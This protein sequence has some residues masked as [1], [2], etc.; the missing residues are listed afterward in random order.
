MKH[1]TTSEFLSVVTPLLQEGDPS[2]LAGAVRGR[3]CGRQ[4]CPL[5]SAG[6]VDVRRAAALVLGLVGD[7]SV[8]GS[9]S[10]ALHD[11]EDSVAAM[12]EHALWSVWHRGG[13][14]AAAGPFQ[15]GLAHLA[16]EWYESAAERFQRAIRLDPHFAEAHNQLAIVLFLWGRWSEARTHCLQ[17]LRLCPTHFGALSGLGHCAVELDDLPQALRCYRQTLAINPRL[18]EIAAMVRQ[19]EHRLGNAQHASADDAELL[20]SG[21]RYA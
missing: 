4:L 3:W 6:E 2:R 9:L 13:N 1:I 11:S 10:R 14:A 21:S 17:A 19:M 16:S 5:L 12:A 20:V 15:D 7:P 18:T 8:V